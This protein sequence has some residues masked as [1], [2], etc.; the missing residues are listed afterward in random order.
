MHS[1]KKTQNIIFILLVGLLFC[2]CGKSTDKWDPV[3]ALVD[4]QMRNF[5]PD[6]KRHALLGD[7]VVF[8]D[9][10]KKIIPENARALLLIN[11]PSRPNNDDFQLNY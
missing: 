8:A 6:Q 1:L 9:I 3:C 7:I 10:C 4:I 2:V 5:N 11:I